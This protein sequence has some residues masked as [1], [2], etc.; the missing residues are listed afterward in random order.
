MNMPDRHRQSGFTLVE[1]MIVV[2]IIAILALFAIPGYQDSVRKSRRDDARVALLETAQRLERCYTQF[3]TY[4]DDDCD[5]DSPFASPEGYY[6]VT[7]VRDATTFTL[8]AAPQGPQAEDTRCGSL[9]VDQA[10]THSATGSI[11]ESCW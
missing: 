4:D 8:T 2:A 10:G 9:A 5:I 3:G 7:L 11:P 1:L 6:S